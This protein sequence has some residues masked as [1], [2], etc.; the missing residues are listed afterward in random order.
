MLENLVEAGET[1][2]ILHLE[3]ALF[4]DVAFYQ[5]SHQQ[6]AICLLADLRENVEV[7]VCNLAMHRHAAG[8][9]RRLD[10]DHVEEV[11]RIFEGQLIVHQIERDSLLCSHGIVLLEHERLLTVLAESLN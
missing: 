7:F 1:D 4:G 11:L 2:G 10:F 6:V 9:L 3:A 5:V 8:D